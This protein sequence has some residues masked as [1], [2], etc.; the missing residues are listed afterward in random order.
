MKTKIWMLATL[1]TL[2]SGCVKDLEVQPLDPTVKSAERTYTTPQNYTEGLMKLYSVW[3]L[4]GQDG[5]GSSDISGLDPGNTVL[6]R[7]WWSLQEATT[8]ET[9][10]SWADSWCA[11]VNGIT[12]STNK[13][14][15]IEGVY[16]RCMYIVSVA[17][18]YLKVLKTAPSEVPTQQY[19]AE[20]R[21]A[22]ALAYYTLL[23][24]FGNPPFITEENYNP[25]PAPIGREA[26][27]GWIEKELLAI[28]PQL[29]APRSLYG[30]A[31]QA[32]ASALLARMYLNAKVY[33]GKERYTDCITQCKQVIAAGYKLATKYADLFKADNGENPDTRQE[34][35]LPFVFDGEQ[36]Q[37]Y[38]M[39]AIIFGSRNGDEITVT[40]H[41]IEGGWSGFRSTYALTSLFEYKNQAQ[42]K[43][44]EILDKRGIFWD[45]NRSQRITT[46]V[47][48]TFSSEGWAVYKY[49]NLKSN[50]KPGSNTKTYPDTDFPYL[51]LADIYLMYAE[52]VAR[53]GEGGSVAEAVNYVNQLRQR[54]Y[55]N[56][57]HNISAQW[58]TQNNFRNILDE[59]A[60]ELYWEGVRRTDLI[61]YNL[62]TSGSYL[63]EGKGGV[64]TGVGVDNRYNLFPIPATDLSVNSN[65]QQNPGY[66]VATAS[67]NK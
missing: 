45:Q 25:T 44:A 16:H 22:R 35:I 12:W 28:Q 58:L 17:N 42:P 11:E 13:V 63:W 8:D 29:P 38:G 31:D 53:G 48:S 30:R 15:P 50:G 36:T 54:A 60:R 6:L 33:T 66:P 9:K 21:F 10:V 40:E 47:T 5:S 26:L 65:L 49:S 39:G 4:S 19:E 3:S 55:G 59:R 27:F 64:I 51:R 52:A 20:A 41:G 23:D 2:C 14:E 34:I 7:S 18:D 43:A 24:L 56:N 57:N 37:S 62:F 61:R 1:V 67:P 32:V 46:S